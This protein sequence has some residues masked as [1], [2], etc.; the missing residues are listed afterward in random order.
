VSPFLTARLEKMVVRSLS[1]QLRTRDLEATLVFYTEKLGFNLDFRHEDFYA[2]VSWGDAVIHFKLVDELDPSIP[3]VRDGGHLHLYLN[4]DSLE[5]L[6][7]L[8]EKRNVVFV[9]GISVKPWGRREFAV[10]DNE[11]HILYFGDIA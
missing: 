7:E 10:E 11:G 2:G 9:H 1:P 6:A 8:Y 3:F 4:V 5:S